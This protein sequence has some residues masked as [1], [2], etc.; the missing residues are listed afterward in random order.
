MCCFAL[1]VVS[2]VATKCTLETC[3]GP[4]RQLFSET[5]CS[6]T[7]FFEELPHPKTCHHRSQ[8]RHEILQC[9]GNNASELEFSNFVSSVGCEASSWISSNGWKT[10]ACLNALYESHEYMSMAYWCEVGHSKS[11]SVQVMEGWHQ[12]AAPLE[13]SIRCPSP[14]CTTNFMA[15]HYTEHD[16][17]GAL[18][19]LQPAWERQIWLDIC[20]ATTDRDVFLRLTLDENNVATVMYYSHR[21][22][23]G[24]EIEFKRIKLEQCVPMPFGS[25]VY[26][27]VNDSLMNE[28]RSGILDTTTLSLTPEMQW[29]ESED[30]TAGFALLLIFGF[31]FFTA[32]SIVCFLKLSDRSNSTNTLPI[33]RKSVPNKDA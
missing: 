12:P 21:C 29:K 19:D 32:A 24:A 11:R 17:T 31:L 3:K 9:N 15:F 2:V 27:Y 23:V 7:S 20:H 22:E 16:C 25:F 6:G 33:R 4:V 26:R 5:D 18:S 28:D 13:E 14:G 1:A 30:F 8:E 10:G